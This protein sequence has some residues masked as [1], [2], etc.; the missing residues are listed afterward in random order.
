MHTFSVVNF[1][2]KL[3]IYESESISNILISN[4]YSYSKNYEDSDIVLVNTCTVTAKADAKC[5][6]IVR[7]IKRTNPGCCLILCGCMVNAEKENL[8]TLHEIDILIENKDKDKISDVLSAYKSGLIKTKPFLYNSDEDG[9]F[10]F[11]TYNMHNHARAFIKIQD[12]C[13]NFCSYCKIPHARGISRSR[14]LEDIIDEVKEIEK[15]GY[16]E[17]IITGINISDYNFNNV[18]L[19]DLLKIIIDNTINIRIRLSSLEPQN[20]DPD[21]YNIIKNDRI[22][23]HF[24]IALQHGSDRILSAMNRKYN[25]SLFADIIKK[26]RDAKPD[27]FISTDIIIGFPGESEKDFEDTIDF[28]KLLNFSFVHIFSFSPRKGTRAYDMTPKIPERIRDERVKLLGEL[29]S[30][31]YNDYKK[32]HLGSAVKVLV[33]KET[34]EGF[35][36]KS[37]NYLDVLIK[38]NGRG[39]VRGTIYKA[40][41]NEIINDELLAGSII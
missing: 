3:N 27:S 39:L 34:K 23:P 37:E 38:C 15:N 30:S 19:S 4:G 25:K 20:I 24:H 16:N 33:I 21:F 17:V 29:T 12:G 14:K 32:N 5:R 11:K 40:V 41:I 9:S 31:L 6:N 13:N 26:I 18:L 7:K 36:G 28:V 1:G 35:M 8:Y 2:C 22:C 10:N